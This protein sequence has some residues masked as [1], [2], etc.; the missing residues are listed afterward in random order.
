[1]SKKT[2]LREIL[3]KDVE[4]F[5]GKLS[6]E[7]YY[8]IKEYKEHLL[9]YFDTYIKEYYENFENY[10]YDSDSD[11]DLN[12]DLNSSSEKSDD[13]EKKIL[14]VVDL[15]AGT[16]A[17][18]YVFHNTGICKT[19]FANDL[20]ENSKKIYDLNFENKL[21]FKNLC[22]IDTKNIPEHEI[23]CSG[24]PCQ[25]FSIAGKK[26][27]FNDKRSNIFWK[28]LDIIKYRKPEV[29][30]LEN[31][32]NLKSHDKGITFKIIKENLEK[33]GYHIKYK[34]INTCD[35]SYLPQNRERIYIVCFKDIKKYN[36]FDFNFEE[37][38]HCELKDFLLKNVPD[39]YYYGP[40]FKVWE[41]IKESVTK[42]ISENVLYQYRR[43]Y[44]R[45]NKSNVCPTLTA[46]MGGGGHNVP[47]LKDEKGIRKLTPR[48]CF[49]LQGFP[50]TYILPDISDSKLYKLSGN[51]V[52]I[53]VITII[54][55]KILNSL[56]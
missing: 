34:V 6:D 8:N 16:G 22:D 37:K 24:F 41:K 9:K 53:P 40:R 46:N 54:C 43:F 42:N 25:P 30:F 31:V 15:C 2:P 32:K 39:N 21:T 20:C 52:S 5:N 56:K 10:F 28:I 51:A 12:S 19:V 4:K 17:F 45:E 26:E 18:S 48:E 36:K 3:P 50:E 14:R 27:G 23:L 35:I 55:N 47:L 13:T 29:I 44:I 33:I 49:M 38:K 1:M 11:S 7:G